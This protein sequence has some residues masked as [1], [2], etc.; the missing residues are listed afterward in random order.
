MRTVFSRI[1]LTVA[2]SLGMAV[3]L[4][5]PVFAQSS[6]SWNQPP[7]EAYDSSNRGY[8]QTQPQQGRS[9]GHLPNRQDQSSRYG[10]GYY[11][12]PTPPNYNHRRPWGEVP[13][14]QKEVYRPRAE[15]RDQRFDH[16]RPSRWDEDRYQRERWRH[17]R[18]TRDR[19]E[20]R[21]W[22]DRRH[23]DWDG[24]FS[25]NPWD[26]TF[27]RERGPF[28]PW[29]LDSYG[30]SRPSYDPWATPNVEGSFR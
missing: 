20:D 17:S 25:Q 14:R 1:H 27:G 23:H 15:E 19:Y 16:N 29:S 26:T 24:G 11:D 2:A 3:I 9:W 30:E 6:S 28:S 8:T 5:T 4:S 13:L 7:R 10:S 22:R 12:S 21:R 18:Q